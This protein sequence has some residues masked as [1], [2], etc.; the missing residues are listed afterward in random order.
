M[1]GEDV[2]AAHVPDLRVRRG[3]LINLIALVSAAATSAAMMIV[4]RLWPG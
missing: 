2:L 3:P 4:D 1:K